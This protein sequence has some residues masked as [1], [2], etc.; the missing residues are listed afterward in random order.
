MNSRKIAVNLDQLLLARKV[1][2]AESPVPG[3]VNR[4]LRMARRSQDSEGFKQLAAIARSRE[5]R[6]LPFII[7]EV[8]LDVAAIL[9]MRKPRGVV[10]S[11]LSHVDAGYAIVNHASCTYVDRYREEHD[12]HGFDFEVVPARRCIDTDTRLS[13][14]LRGFS[15]RAR[16]VVDSTASIRLSWDSRLEPMSS[17]SSPSGPWFQLIDPGSKEKPLVLPGLV[18]ESVKKR[19]VTIAISSPESMIRL[20]A[21]AGRLWLAVNTTKVRAVFPVP[22]FDDGAPDMPAWMSVIL[23]ENWAVGRPDG[24]DVEVNESVAASCLAAFRWFILPDPGVM[25]RILSKQNTESLEQQ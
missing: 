22:S 18:V 4:A 12:P 5:G 15:P 2:P 24:G 17:Q 1:A 20:S 3:T 9:M 11:S 16:G 13:A 7:E 23:P 19:S 8:D 25:V 10:F 21:A 6:V 14:A